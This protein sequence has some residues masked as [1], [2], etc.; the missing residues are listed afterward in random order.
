MAL[1]SWLIASSGLCCTASSSPKSRWAG[2][3]PP[4]T[5]SFRIGFDLQHGL[6]LLLRVVQAALLPIE[7]SQSFH[8]AIIVRLRIRGV[9]EKGLVA[10]P[11]R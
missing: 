3:S 1:S 9:A 8:G 11:G 10:G 7:G 6:I 2:S 4:S 5:R